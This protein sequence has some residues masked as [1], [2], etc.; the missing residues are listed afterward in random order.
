[1]SSTHGQR[2]DEPDPVPA[3]DETAAPPS[4]EPPPIVDWGRTARRMAIS[5]AT[6]STVIVV[7]WLGFGV[8]H[9]QLRGRLLGELIGLGLLAAFAAEFVIVGGAALRG[10]LRAGDRGD[11]L[12]GADVSLLPPQILRRRRR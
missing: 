8:V 1:M 5:V 11:R 10:M 3:A 2:A 6:I 4:S 7:A 9:G 12:A